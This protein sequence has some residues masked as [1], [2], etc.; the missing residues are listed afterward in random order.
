MKAGIRLVARVK[1]EGVWGTETVEPDSRG[2][3]PKEPEGVSHFFLRYSDKSWADAERRA[4]RR[5]GASNVRLE[6]V[7]S[8]YETAKKLYADKHDERDRAAKGLAPFAP[9]HVPAHSASTN[10][11]VVS[12]SIATAA[13]KY[14]TQLRDKQLAWEQGS[15][16]EN[17]ILAPETV[18]KYRRTIEDFRDYIGVKNFGDLNEDVILTYKHGLRK[19]T[20]GD[21]T[22]DRKIADA[23]V[24]IGAFLRKHGIQLVRDE[25]GR[26][27]IAEE[28]HT[29]LTKA[30][31]R[32]KIPEKYS[33]VEVEA[34]RKATI[35]SKVEAKDAVLVEE[36]Q[37]AREIIETF[38]LT[39]M[40]RKEVAHLTYNRLNLDTNYILLADQPKYRWRLKDGERRNTPL[41][42]E[43]RMLLLARKARLKADDDALVFPSPNRL[44]DGHQDRIL[45][46]IAE[47]A[48]EQGTKI[49]GEIGLHKFRK[50]WATKLLKSHPIDSVRRWGGWSSLEVMQAY[51]AEEEQVDFTK[52][53]KF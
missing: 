47:R 28:N 41:W 51:L 34:L 40:R 3:W 43:L 24:T 49:K 37:T 2:R 18:R 10:G 32:S 46:W 14:F 52:A 16:V 30:I 17:D 26:G 21:G 35:P 12:G 19:R 23:F 38:L 8:H 33:D 4:G 29:P 48:A 22:H 42:P 44:P 27:L 6:H 7:G 5:T 25:S 45:K 9:V 13:E 11:H 36:L 31:K 50:S 15:K 39:G 53:P 1:A 20:R